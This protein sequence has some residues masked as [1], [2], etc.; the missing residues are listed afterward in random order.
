MLEARR[1]WTGDFEYVYQDQSS[2][3]GAAMLGQMYLSGECQAGRTVAAGTQP[4]GAC[5][6][7]ASRSP[8]RRSRVPRPARSRASAASHPSDREDDD[9][10]D[11]DDDQFHDAP[12]AIRATAR[13]LEIWWDSSPLVFETWRTNMLASADAGAP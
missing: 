6:D 10:H 5:A 11:H 4:T 7:H 2:M 9:A 8:S 13:G 1:R 3:V 12:G